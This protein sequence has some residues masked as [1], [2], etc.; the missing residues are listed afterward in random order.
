ME[1]GFLAVFSG[2]T[3]MFNSLIMTIVDKYI[4]TVFSGPY[5]FMLLPKFVLD[6]HLQ[7]C[8]VVYSGDACNK[9][10]NPY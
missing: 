4:R 5:G 3:A 10:S 7:G 9:K 8:A 1:K 2:R 6:H